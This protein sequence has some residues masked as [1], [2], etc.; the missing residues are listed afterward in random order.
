MAR[1]L[2]RE[3]EEANRVR[4]DRHLA[5]ENKTRHENDI[6]QLEN[7]LAGSDDGDTSNNVALVRALEAVKEYLNSVEYLDRCPVCDQDA[8]SEAMLR[9]VRERLSDLEDYSRF[10]DDLDQAKKDLESAETAVDQYSDELIRVALSILRKAQL[11]GIDEEV[12]ERLLFFERDMS[13]DSQGIR[14]DVSV[15][16]VKEAQQVLHLVKSDID[17]LSKHHGQKKIVFGL[18]QEYQ[19]HVEDAKRH[20]A[21]G[22][23]LQQSLATIRQTRIRF[24]QEL[25]YEIEEAS[26]DLYMRLHPGE[27]ISVAGLALDPQNRASLNQS[28][29]F[30]THED[31]APQ[32]YLSEAH[33]DTL[34]FCF[35]L[36]FAKRESAKAPVILVLDDVFTSV[37]AQHTRRLCELVSDERVNFE[38]IIITTHQRRW[39]DELSNSF[40]SGKHAEIY[41]LQTWSLDRGVNVGI[42]LAS[43]KELRHAVDS[44]RIDRQGIASK[45]G[46][47]LE[48]TLDRLT[49][50]FGCPMPRSARPTYDLRTLLD[51]SASLFKE[52]RSKRPILDDLGTPLEPSDYEH[53]E[54][55]AIHDELRTIYEIR[56]LVGAHYNE[57]GDEVPDNDIRRLG[58]LALKLVAFLEC[59]TCGMV[60]SKR[61]DDRFV[62]GCPPKKA[63]YLYKSQAKAVA[64]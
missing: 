10:A 20:A 50:Q 59:P 62:C 57:V 6:R 21:T 2:A 28:V 24:T 54:A 14:L 13:S 18:Y 27:P 34:G 64:F 33:L 63:S 38:K 43:T 35:W 17:R 55:K 8:E 19:T 26:R 52:L 42:G 39:R 56:N 12:R 32:P 30:D 7:L 61:D 11:E 3:I 4:R 40:G 60:P 31:V 45:S 37:D 48:Q 16:L 25:L 36:A 53:F 23:V 29:T 58:Q 44:E 1:E 47:L 51:C 15:D 9:L 22:Q 41:D 49:L 46:V 5:I